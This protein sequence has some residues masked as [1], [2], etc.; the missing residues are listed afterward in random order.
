MLCHNML[1]L[2]LYYRSTLF[3]V[4][5]ERVPSLCI[6]SHLFELNNT[7]TAPNIPA[8][9]TADGLNMLP[10][11]FLFACHSLIPKMATAT[12]S[13]NSVALFLALS[14]LQTGLSLG[15]GYK[16]L[17]GR[18]ISRAW[19]SCFQN[20]QAPG[21]SFRINTHFQTRFK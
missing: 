7:K 18:D 16:L 4:F 19:S 5:F 2:Y 6:K 17:L 21:E 15:L 20:V 14:L 11:V 13:V 1:C 8:E 3:L 10:P 12:V 9:I